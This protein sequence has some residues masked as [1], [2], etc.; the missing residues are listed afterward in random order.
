MPQSLEDTLLSIWRQTLIE[1]ANAVNLDGH[2]YPV[3]ITKGRKTKN[4]NG[5]PAFFSRFRVSFFRD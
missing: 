1:H 2:T 5:F 4:R 3:Q